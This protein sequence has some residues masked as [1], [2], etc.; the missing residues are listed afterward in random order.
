MRILP[1]H[2]IFS[3][4]FGTVFILSQIWFQALDGSSQIGVFQLRQ[5]RSKCVEKQCQQQ[6]AVEG[7]CLSHALECLSKQKKN[8]WYHWAAT[9]TFSHAEGLFVP[10]LPSSIPT[11]Q[12]PAPLII[13][14]S[15]KAISVNNL[16]IQTK[17]NQA[18]KTQHYLL[19]SFLHFDVKYI[20]WYYTLYFIAAFILPI[21]LKILNIKPRQI[22]MVTCHEWIKGTL[23]IPPYLLSGFF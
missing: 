13:S 8:T 18:A 22:I 4:W 10:S 14:I 20:F 2:L 6:A 7:I 19:I 9:S 16:N 21:S 3:H 15:W 23:D 12:L 5:K 1:L 11:A 17:K